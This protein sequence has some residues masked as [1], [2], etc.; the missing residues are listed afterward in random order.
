MCP[1]A[2]LLVDEVLVLGN[3]ACVILQLWQWDPCLP[4]M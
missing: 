1:D 3:Y 4:V 2:L